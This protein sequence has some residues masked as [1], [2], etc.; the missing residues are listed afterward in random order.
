MAVA[1]TLRSG[2]LASFE[3][4][5]IAERDGSLAYIA[6]PDGRTTP[7]VFMLTELSPVS[8]TFENPTHDYPKL[9]RYTRKDDGS[10]ETTI[11]G[12]AGARAQ[13]VTLRKQ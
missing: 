7:T 5:C 12:E 8:V 4:L 2:A 9:V 3:F 6:M 10:L 11:A 13:T 1:R